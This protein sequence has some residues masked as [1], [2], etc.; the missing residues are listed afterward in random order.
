[1]EF[2]WTILYVSDV[3]ASVSFYEAAFGLKRRM[4]S[5][6]GGYA[7][8]DTGSTRLAFA[9]VEFAKSHLPGGVTPHSP[10]GT[11]QALELAFV[12]ADVEAGF[13]QALAAGA[14]PVAEPEQMPWGQ[15]VS[16]VRDPE[17]ILIE[18]ATD[19]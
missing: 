3:R 9:S 18:V 4:M 19:V 2:R 17:G 16:W 11:P 15:V 1:M 7:E 8:M 12:T 10:S 6:E 5:D 13:K 14:T